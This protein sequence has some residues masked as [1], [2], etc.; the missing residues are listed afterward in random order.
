MTRLAAVG[1]GLI[2]LG[3]EPAPDAAVTL[4]FGGDAANAAVMAARLG[5]PARFGGRLGNDALGRRLLGF[6]RDADIDVEHVLL[7]AGAP[8]GI[9]VNER[10]AEG[11]H[12]FDYHRAGSAGSRLGPGDIG[13]A[14]LDDVGMLHLTGITRAVSGTSRDAALDLAARARAREI[15][16]SVA[17]NHRPALGGSLETL[18]TTAQAADVVFVSEEE[19]GTVFDRSD[20]GGL[21]RELG[22]AELIL[23]RGAQGATLVTG[24]EH[25]DVPALPVETVDAAGAGDAL[26]GAYLAARLQGEAPL[27]ALRL[28]I[29]AAGLSCRARGCALSYPDRAEVTAAA[30]EA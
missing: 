16:V 20:A 12:R 7:D 25:M 28:G 13:D 3:L 26:A 8:T 11:L 6:W 21:A 30:G 2:E 22:A 19:A 14:F 17:V 24:G 4:G 5:V 23:T 1:E 27:R 10:G 9:Y 18:R 29:A 15:R